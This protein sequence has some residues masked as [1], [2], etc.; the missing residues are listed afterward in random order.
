MSVPNFPP[1][2]SWC[3][4]SGS[5]PTR[6]RSAGT[7]SGREADDRGRDAGAGEE[8]GAGQEAGTGEEAGARGEGG[9]AGAG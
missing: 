3:W 5:S 6:P 4:V 8:P 9:A 1:A 7:S 2:S